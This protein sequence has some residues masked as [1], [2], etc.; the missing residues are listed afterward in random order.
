MKTQTTCTGTHIRAGVISLLVFALCY[1]WATGISD[2]PLMW[3]FI[4]SF[5]VCFVLMMQSVVD[6]LVWAFSQAARFSGAGVGHCVKLLRRAISH[7]SH[8]A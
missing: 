4:I 6:L 5:A 3:L 2:L 8:A 1:L 7:D